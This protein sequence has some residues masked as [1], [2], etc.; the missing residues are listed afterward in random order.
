MSNSC[1][2]A[3]VVSPHNHGDHAC[4]APT[5]QRMHSVVELCKPKLAVPLFPYLQKTVISIT[6]PLQVYDR[7]GNAGVSVGNVPRIAVSPHLAA[8]RIYVSRTHAGGTFSRA[9]SRGERRPGPRARFAREIPRPEPISPHFPETRALSA[10]SPPPRTPPR[11][12]P[13]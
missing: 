13:A 5:T 8:A 11:F 4:R 12:S 6:K 1:V 10:P 7:K 2:V 9:P 3:A